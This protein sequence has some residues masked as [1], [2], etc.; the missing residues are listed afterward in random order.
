MK[1]IF[2]GFLKG[3]SKL[4][5][6][7]L[8]AFVIAIIASDNSNIFYKTLNEYNITDPVAQKGILSAA[9]AF[10]IGSVDL[11]LK[12]LFKCSLWI[13]GKYFKRLKVSIHFKENSR[14]KKTI[15]FKPNNGVYK[16]ERIDIEVEVVPAGKISLFILKMLGL[17]IQVF[18]NPHI[19]DVTLENDQEWLGEQPVTTIDDKQAVCISVLKNYSIKGSKLKPFKT[20]ESIVIVPKRV[21][22]DTAHIDFRLSS[23]FGSKLSNALCDSDMKDLDI[24]CER[25]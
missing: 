2:L 1:K 23:F 17:Q 13:I 7:G 24:E 4:I 20:T 8:I 5:V 16:E 14:S 25:G 11:L 15:K 12:L 18:F 10:V 19:L 9:I 21:K 22:R 3:F 6:T